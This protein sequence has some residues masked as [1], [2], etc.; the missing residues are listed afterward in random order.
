MEM[1]YGSG[2]S[3]GRF[4]PRSSS[5]SVFSVE[6]I[7]PLQEREEVVLNGHPISADVVFRHA[8]ANGFGRNM[9]HTMLLL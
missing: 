7:H 9:G 1:G 4:W 6:R 2:L 3:D 5:R 8:D